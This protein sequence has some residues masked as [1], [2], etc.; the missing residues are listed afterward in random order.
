MKSRNSRTNNGYI[1]QNR[2]SDNYGVISENKNYLRSN[3]TQWIRPANWLPLPSMTA[4]D[5]MFAGLFAVYPG[6]SVL[7]GPTA[8]GNFVAFSITGCPYTVDWGNGTTQSYSAG[9]TAQNNFDF[10]SISAATTITGTGIAGLTG[11]R[12]T[13]ITAY[14]T[15]A[16]TTFS[17]IDLSAKYS[18]AGY[19]FG[20]NWSPAWLDIRIAGSTISSFRCV[21]PFNYN[22]NQF[23]WVGNSGIT[24]GANLFS[25]A[26]SLKSL[27]GTSWTSNI[28]TVLNA[29]NACPIR[30]IPLLNTAN[31]T[32]FSNMFGS[33]SALQT[34]P[35]L[36]T[37]NCTNFSFMF[38]SCRSLETIPLLNTANG[39][40]F[41]S[42]FSNCFS[43]Q[44]IP[45]LNTEKGTSFRSMFS[46]CTSL[47]TIPKLDTS[48]GNNFDLMFNFCTSLETIPLLNTANGLTFQS[49]F[50]NCT[51]LETI[52]LLDL[53]KSFIIQTMF[54]NCTALQTIPVLNFGTPVYASQPFAGCTNLKQAATNAPLFSP[55]SVND[56]NLSPA[57]INDV[58]KNLP[59]G[60]AG[61]QCYIYNNWG[62][63]GCDRTIAQNKGWIVIG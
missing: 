44:T 50:S 14:P 27:I 20:A 41:E 52:P 17:G 36:N 40:N 7:T 37:A 60:A 56:L 19:T 1:G 30:T 21:S 57:A 55:W 22:I 46:N 13:V 3:L 32:N 6:D 39:T 34:I 16:G 33:C 12:Q 49:M 53:S 11:Y 45:L 58:F 48:S 43:L 5:Q 47:E 28:I 10:Q 9:A 25:G 18:Q 23:E 61:R 15:V 51:S 35:L 8:S 4:G 54:N 29:F 38:S 42:M 59:T 2:L 63:A 31:C 26:K 62:A 24:N